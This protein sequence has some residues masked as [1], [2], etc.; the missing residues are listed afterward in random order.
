MYV[1]PVVVVPSNGRPYT[2]AA[3]LQVP[4][5]SP[6]PYDVL[7]VYGRPP[8]DPERNNLDRQKLRE[9][10]VDSGGS[11]YV[12]SAVAWNENDWLLVYRGGSPDAPTAINLTQL[13]VVA[14]TALFVADHTPHFYLTSAVNPEGPAGTTTA[15][16][17]FSTIDL[18]HQSTVAIHN[19]GHATS[20]TENP[21]T[22]DLL[23]AGF[24]M[25][26]IPGP[27]TVPDPNAE[28]FFEARL[29]RIMPMQVDRVVASRFSE[30]HLALPISAV[31]MAS[32]RPGDLDLDGDVD[33]SDFILFQSC[34]T[35]PGEERSVVCG[36]ADLDGDGDVDLADLVVLQGSLMALP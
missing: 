15:L 32:R 26:Q 25:P 35:G 30:E 13:D 12:T 33:L 17:R 27:D 31:W 3:K 16:F 21:A 9:I 24:S 36:A 7:T 28:P 18:T 29:A 14:P 20:I 4:G 10:E 22:G 1:L 8:P 34:F 11:V 6:A 5:T 2:A 19:M 23:I